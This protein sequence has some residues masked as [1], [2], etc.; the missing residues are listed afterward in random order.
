MTHR[1]TP[2]TGSPQPV[3]DSDIEHEVDRAVAHFEGDQIG[4]RLTDALQAYLRTVEHLVSEAVAAAPPAA[5][6]KLPRIFAEQ[7]P[8]SMRAAA[9]TLESGFRAAADEFDPPE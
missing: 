3:K 4:G 7:I 5:V 2:E 9:D 1:S 6:R 8:S